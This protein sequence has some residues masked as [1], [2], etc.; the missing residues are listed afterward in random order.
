MRQYISQDDGFR[1]IVTKH[2]FGDVDRDLL[3]THFVNSYLD[4][5]IYPR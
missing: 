2:H 4:T 5:T 1:F 3:P